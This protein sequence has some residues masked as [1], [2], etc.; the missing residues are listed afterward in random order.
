MS[1]I[2]KLPIILPKNVEIALEKNN[3]RVKGPYGILNQKIPN[4]FKIIV[5]TE[6]I[7]VINTETTK[8]SNQ[9]YGLIR[10]LIKNMVFG[11]TN[12]FSQ[13]LQIIGVGYRA[14]LHEK[15]LILNIGYSHTKVFNI[16]DDIKIKIDNNTLILTGISKEKVGTFAAKI[17]AVRPPEPYKGK[18]I[19]YFE[20]IVLRK[21]GKSGKK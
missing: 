7:K 10:S 4:E 16:S 12:Q 2:G 18:G 20:E 17:R 15:N 14:H 1:R 6:L 8:S 9:K 19:R 13:K 3:F 21:A 11:V 5:T